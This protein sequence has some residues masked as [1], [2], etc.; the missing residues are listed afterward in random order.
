MAELVDARD[1]KSRDGN[2]VRVRFPLWAPTEDISADVVELVDTHASGACARKSVWVQVP[3][4][5]QKNNLFSGC[6]S[7]FLIYF[8]KE[9]NGELHS[10]KG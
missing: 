1:S 10:Q 5:V 9:K 4:S 7:F 8:L 6:F 2:I 3:P